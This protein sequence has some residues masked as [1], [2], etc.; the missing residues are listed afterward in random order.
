MHTRTRRLQEELSAQVDADA[1]GKKAPSW[2]DFL[3]FLCSR[4]TSHDPNNVRS[5]ELR[6]SR[7]GHSQS[8]QDF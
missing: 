3:L 1:V 2:G 4:T 8:K 5:T 7:F 6:M